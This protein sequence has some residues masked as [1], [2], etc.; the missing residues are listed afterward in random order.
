MKG[1]EHMNMLQ[2]FITVFLM[3]ACL[4]PMKN[5]TAE[6]APERADFYRARTE[7]WE[8]ALGDYVRWHYYDRAL[9]CAIYGRRP[10]DFINPEHVQEDIPK[11]PPAECLSYEEA[12]RI[13]K[14]FLSDYEPR[15]TE[16]Y[17]SG[18]HVG[19]A[20]YDFWGNPRNTVTGTA[21]AQVWIIQFGEA[22]ASGDYMVR[23]DAYIDAVT[24]RVVCI[25]IGIDMRYPDDWDH[26]RTISLNE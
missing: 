7:E 12:L 2:R 24:G 16:A 15:I 3:A 26:F 13:A 17:L 25:D 9:F 6:L 23:C 8:H 11:F 14:A 4:L 22:H 19:S 1:A 5:G 10:G 21:H 18:L 20:Y